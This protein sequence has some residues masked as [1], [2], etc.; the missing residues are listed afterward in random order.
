MFST[1]SELIFGSSGTASTLEAEIPAS[2]GQSLQ[3]SQSSTSA[4][5]TEV[6]ENDDWVIVK[7]EEKCFLVSSEQVTRSRVNIHEDL[8]RENFLIEHP[9]SLSSEEIELRVIKLRKKRKGKRNGSIIVPRNPCRH[10]PVKS[11]LFP[12][13][14][15]QSTNLRPLTPLIIFGKNCNQGPQIRRGDSKR[16]ENYHY[17]KYSGVNNDR[18]SARQ[19]ASS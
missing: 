8:S 7:D 10:N 17:R 19:R 6:D 18:R 4:P 11:L 1:L 13:P 5:G 12:N 9:L 14:L 16:N 15:T 2:Q 3:G